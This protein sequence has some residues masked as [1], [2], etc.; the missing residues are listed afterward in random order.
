MASAYDFSFETLQGKPYALKDLAGRP[1]VVV[2]TA[3]KCGF[4]PQY[5]ALEGVWKA[6]QAAGLVV[7]GVPCNDFGGQE[8]GSAAEIGSFCEL[9]YGVDFPIMAKVHAKGPDAHPFFKWVA[10]EAG[11]MA[12]PRW[13]FYKYLIN[14]QGE[15]EEWFSSIT[16]PDSKKFTGEVQKLFY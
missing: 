4:T 3:S 8:P 1:L 15:L 11:F 2:N 13:N 16:K 10:Q 5:K 9:N 7:I 12:K 14:K 6:F